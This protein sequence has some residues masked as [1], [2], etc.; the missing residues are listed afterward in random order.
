[1]QNTTKVA[2]I[3]KQVEYYFSDSNFRRDKFLQ[4]SVDQDGYVKIATLLTFNKLKSLTME[5]QVVASSIEASESI[6]L[7]QD[8]TAIRRKTPLP[9]HDD[10]EERTIVLGG[11]GKTEPTIEQVKDLF[12][13]VTV[14][15]VRTA[16][17]QNSFKGYAYVEF[18][19]KEDTPTS[20]DQS[21]SFNDRV[22]RGLPLSLYS[23]MDRMD[24][25]RLQRGCNSYPVSFIIIDDVTIPAD[26]GFRA[27]RKLLSAELG[28]IEVPFLE[29]QNSRLT[30]SFGSALNAEKALSLLK[31]K[32]FN[33][34]SIEKAFLTQDQPKC[35]VESKKG[36]EYPID[37]TLTKIQFTNVP[38]NVTREG[39]LE[40][41]GS[42]W[43]DAQVNRYIHFKVGQ[44]SGQ[45][46][47][48]SLAFA[49]ALLA[50]IAEHPIKFGSDELEFKLLDPNA[51]DQGLIVAIQDVPK[52]MSRED[53][54]EKLG[55]F[56]STGEI[57]FVDW[58]QKAADQTT[59]YVRSSDKE[60]SAEILKALEQGVEVSDQIKLS[61]AHLLTGDEEKEYWMKV[62]AIRESRY[63]KKRSSDGRQ[64]QSKYKQ[65][66]R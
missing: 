6:E 39:I 47:V 4:S 2:A 64:R 48:K 45:L 26:G 35:S 61:K 56:A 49:K 62:V 17:V 50:R 5:S 31:E 27:L 34:G 15:S 1:M 25:Q 42:F 41:L 29:H 14:T 16:R 36:T 30:M 65:R 58:D 60:T 11:F 13:D 7:N 12:K 3:K 23:K 46:H 55:A 24:R 53:I 52:D 21:Y 57:A 18:K 37:S 33:V 66:R 22:I 59:A 63:A 28:S 32:K 8:K 43:S 40:Q 54:K 44:T 38:E 19:N 10:S 51:Y 9:E 20:A